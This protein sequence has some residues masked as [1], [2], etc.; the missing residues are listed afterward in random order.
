M[1]KVS[2]DLDTQVRSKTSAK[3]LSLG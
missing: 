3:N 1:S 2:D